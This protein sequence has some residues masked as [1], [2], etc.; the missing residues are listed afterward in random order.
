MQNTTSI[1]ADFVTNI[2]L[3]D[4]PEMAIEEAK[5]ILLDSLECA[6]AGLSSEK[7]RISLSLASRYE[8]RSEAT[9]I[10]SKIRSPA[11]LAAFVN[12]ELIN[13]L[14]FDAL[15]QPFGHI[16]PYVL[17][18]ILSLGELTKASG[19]DFLVALVV[20]HEIAQRVGLGLVKSERFLKILD[21]NRVEIQLP[22]N[23]YGI[24]IFGA[25]AGA[26]K[27][28]G[29][30]MEQLEHAMG[31]GSSLCPIPTLIKF[32]NTVP[33]SM[34]KFSPTG[35]IAQAAV[36]AVFLS[37]S[38]YIGDRNVFDGDF[39]FWKSFG[40]DGWRPEYVT[41]GLGHYWYMAEGLVS[42]KR[43]PCCG[44]MHPGIDILRSIIKKYAIKPK[45]IRKLNVVMNT[46]AEL[47]LWKNRKITSH[48][49]AQ[50]SVPYVF[51][52]ACHQ[53]DIGYKWQAPHTYTDPNILRLMER[54]NVVTPASPDYE[55]KDCMVELIV[56]DRE[57]KKEIKYTEKDVY[58][59]SFEMK[60]EE[61]LEKFRLNAQSI[62]TQEKIQKVIKYVLSLEEMEELSPLMDALMPS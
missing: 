10:G 47:P 20:A 56:W 29:L 23:G 41:Q 52:V 1:L 37:A 27:L 46:L 42:Y 38:G 24:T 44:A 22:I 45:D 48:I 9:I 5:K 53:I 30:S 7:G 61:I 14:D 49:D 50:F 43:Y 13:A 34:S 39:A 17:S 2:E 12:G 58:P 36:T 32:V 25:I 4:I 54:I 8:G 55:K 26:G 51:S 62:L 59:I 3:Q 11:P 19:E 21:E 60:H 15:L 33:G 6:L 40:A 18:S 28:Y 31:I 16:S 35:W 57:K